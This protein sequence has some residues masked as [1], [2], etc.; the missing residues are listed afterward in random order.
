[1][2]RS[3]RIP[4]SLRLVVAAVHWTILDNMSALDDGSQVHR[5]QCGVSSHLP[6]F[7]CEYC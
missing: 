1:M 4:M 2:L 6:I 5:L 3:F 7:L